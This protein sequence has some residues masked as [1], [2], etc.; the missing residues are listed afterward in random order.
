MR[1]GDVLRD[2]LKY[3]GI[4]Q[5]QLAEDLNIAPSTIGNYIRNIREPDFSTLKA[6]ADYFQVST[7]YLLDHAQ[8]R[9]NKTLSRQ[10][11]NLLYLYQ[12]LTPEQQKIYLEQGKVFLQHN[13][14]LP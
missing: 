6:F 4:S 14:K 3:E 5:K 10:E 8:V 13:K 11:Q 9:V 2:L 7:D 12:S 1:F